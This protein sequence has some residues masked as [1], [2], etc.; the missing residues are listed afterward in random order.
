MA[1]FEADNFRDG[2][3]ASKFED[4][5]RACKV[6]AD[7]SGRIHSGAA[8]GS[9]VAGAG[10]MEMAAGSTSKMLNWGA[11]SASANGPSARRGRAL[12][13]AIISRGNSIRLA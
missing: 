1:E 8:G 5:G 11:D 4:G 13:V 3:N 10:W 9:M 12:R 7:H 2:G 6:M